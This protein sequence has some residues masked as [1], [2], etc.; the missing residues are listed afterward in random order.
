M[1]NS[2]LTGC[3]VKSGFTPGPDS[4]VIGGEKWGNSLGLFENSNI[5]SFDINVISRL[6]RGASS[7]G[8]VPYLGIE[9]LDVEVAQ[10]IESIGDRGVFKDPRLSIGFHHLHRLTPAAREGKFICC[11]RSP[12]SVARSLAKRDSMSVHDSFELWELF[13]S[14]ALGLVR[15]GTDVPFMLVDFDVLIHDDHGMRDNL[16]EFVGTS[17]DFSHLTTSERHWEE[18]STHST[19]IDLLNSIQRGDPSAFRM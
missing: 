8:K 17:L 5:V 1:R 11:I 13:I 19:Y 7:W 10:Y 9:P 2:A 16:C 3:L 12:E 14:A 6:E 4:D 15:D 18:K